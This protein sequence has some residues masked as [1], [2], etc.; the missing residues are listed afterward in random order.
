M[1]APYSLTRRLTGRVLA[2]VA[3]G[4]LAAA[5]G[6]LWVLD[7]EAGETLDLALKH[8]AALLAGLAGAGAKLPPLVGGDRTL[9]I[10]EADG[11]VNGGADEGADGGADE[12]GRANGG[13]G[14]DGDVCAHPNSGAGAQAGTADRPWP[15]APAGRTLWTGNGWAVARAPLPDG[16]SVELGEPL[17]RRR[18]ELG[19]AVRGLVFVM[20]PVTLALMWV[21][22]RTLGQAMR[23][24]GQLTRALAD[25][26][27]A[28]LAPLDAAGLP[29]ELAP[30]AHGMNHYL[31]RI[32]G[33]IAAERDFAANAAHE[34]RTPVAAARAEAQLLAAQPATA[35]EAGRIVAAL[36]RI[37]SLTE[38]LLQLSR[39]E[40]GVGL[41]RA[42][43]DLTRL[44]PLMLADLPA[45]ADRPL[46]YDD[47]DL[48]AA[49][50]QGDADGLAILI[51]NLADNALRHGTGPVRITLGQGPRLT[52]TN[53]VDAEARFRPDRLDRGPRSQGT[54]LGL[55]IAARLAEQSGARL[56]T[57]IAHGHAT[58][59]LD[60]ARRD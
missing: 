25:R 49:V 5:T 4:W 26:D 31:V 8:E 9:R 35:A 2:L 30:V 32:R 22:R 36:D 60:W 56:T 58:V 33:L 27:A 54:G 37:T 24:V 7:D 57:A 6:A 12:G 15:P 18:E 46:R 3:L 38:R 17:G 40:A 52:V 51:R 42:P 1:S 47:G 43:V 34:L 21:V 20:L 13:G 55:T 39:A 14:R 59:M 50:V 23:P 29:A 11:R 44:L 53:P 10:I 48:D 45:A 41:T 28:D 19:E 16:R